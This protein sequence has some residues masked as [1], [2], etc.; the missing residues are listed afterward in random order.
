MKNNQKYILLALIAGLLML[1]QVAGAFSVNLDPP[2][3]YLTMAPGE[4]QRGVLTLKNQGKEK[5]SFKVY[6]NDWN[7][8]PDG[9]KQFLPAGKA[10]YSCA[11]WLKLDNARFELAPGAEQK[12]YYQITAPLK[13][14]GG[15]YA[16]VFF[17]SVFGVNK[18]NV[19][20]AGRI[21]TIFYV[22]IK[23]TAKK[24]GAIKDFQVYQ[25]L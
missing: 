8:L 19:N 14:S 17:E 16:V 13:A 6:T 1:P 5:S 11:N 23:D 9:S 21:G 2:S 7:Y 20:L 12:A 15:Y 10:K 3:V 4:T 18:E 25:K 22:E 24:Q